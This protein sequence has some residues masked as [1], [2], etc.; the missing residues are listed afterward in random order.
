MRILRSIALSNTI[1]LR[2]VHL[3]WKIKGVTIEIHGSGNIELKAP[4]T[5]ISNEESPCTYRKRLNM[6]GTSKFFGL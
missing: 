2:E 6:Q 5:S 1:I 3:G 4:I